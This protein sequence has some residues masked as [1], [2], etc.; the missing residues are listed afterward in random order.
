MGTIRVKNI[1][2][3]IKQSYDAYRIC[4]NMIYRQYYSVCRTAC[5]VRQQDLHCTG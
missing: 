1:C 5:D 3:Y 4:T 2:K